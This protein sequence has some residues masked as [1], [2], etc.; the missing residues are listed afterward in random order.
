MKPRPVPLRTCAGCREQRAKRDMI[1]VVHALDGSVRVDLTGK[2]NGRGAYVCPRPECWSLALRT[3]S[4]GRVLKT[5]I[6]EADLTELKS[7][8]ESLS[9]APSSTAEPSPASAR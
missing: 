4:L 6:V 7:F 9:E 8:G 3:G 5:S 1:R 2:V